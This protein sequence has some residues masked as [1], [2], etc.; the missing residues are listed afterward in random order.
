MYVT[1]YP[2]HYCARHIVASGID[3][4]QFIE[5]YPKS[6]ATELH[7]DSI[8]TESSDW[9]PPSQGGTHVLFRPFVGVAPQLY[10]RVFLKDRSYKDKISGDFVFGTPAWGRPTEVYKVSYSAMEAELALEVD[11]A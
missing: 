3:E 4:V 1:T 6:K 10:R 9:S 8:T 5:P 2:C 11:S 7:S